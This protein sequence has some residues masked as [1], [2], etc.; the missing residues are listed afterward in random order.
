MSSRFNKYPAS[1]NNMVETKMLTLT[2][3]LR[4][5][6]HT[7]AQTPTRTPLHKGTRAGEKR[8][9]EVTKMT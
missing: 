9:E 1:K 6:E 7:S 8:E 5:Y 2:S 3:G 4:T